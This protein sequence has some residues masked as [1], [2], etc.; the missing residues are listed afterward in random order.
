[1]PNE[2]SIEICLCLTLALLGGGH[3]TPLFGQLYGFQDNF[4]RGFELPTPKYS[5]FWDM[6]KI[7]VGFIEFWTLHGKIKCECF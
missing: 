6:Y 5:K 1:M 4:F 7:L 2:M 3:L